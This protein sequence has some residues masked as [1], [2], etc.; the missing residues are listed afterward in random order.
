MSS[1]TVNGR[2]QRRVLV[3]W[4]PDWPVVAAMAEE[5]TP[6]GAPVVVVAGNAVVACNDAARAEGVRRGMRRRDAQSRCPRLKV[7]ADN[8][9]RDANAFEPVLLAVEE[10]RPGVAPLRPGLLAVHAP[11]RYYGSETAAGAVIAEQLVELGVWD[12]RI[13]VA[14]DLFT[15]EQAARRAEPQDSFVVPAGGSPTFLRELPVDVL[16]DTD[17]VSLLRR[18]GVRTLGDLAALPADDVQARFGAYGAKVH[19]L[20]RGDDTTP[21]ATR[22]PPP[23][24]TCQVAFE[25]PLESAEAVRFSVRQTAE[26]FVAQIAGHGLVCTQV[27]IEVECDRAVASARSWAHSRWFDPA[28]L[29]DR[30]HWQLSGQLSS[31]RGGPGGVRFS[32]GSTGPGSSVPDPV[33]LV[34]FIPETV[35]PVATHAQGLWGAGTDERVE[36]AVARVQGLLG[37][38]AVTVPLLQGGRSP[39]DQQALVPWGERPVGLRPVEPP[40]PGSLPPPAPVRIFTQPQRATVLDAPGQP[41]RVDVRGVVSAPPA[42]FCA[43]ATGTAGRDGRSGRRAAGRVP[44]PGQGGGW[45]PVTAWAGPWPVDEQWWEE[46]PD[47]RAARFQIVGSDGR[48]W[49]MRCDRDGWWIE[50]GYD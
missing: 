43:S 47:H 36:R 2:A 49:L 8:A 25:P 6:R 27:R 21:L 41:V 32:A 35:E 29:A 5:G 45:Q 23:E 10:L 14:D 16:D 1:D 3:V 48:A 17:V 4:C 13:G 39:A 46:G 19:R 38:G 15:A 34:R 11:G 50:A 9:D 24:W 26:R 7:L 22:T 44:E 12:C 20:A 31:Q 30:V 40:W 42:R 33:E 28:D 18:L 37:H